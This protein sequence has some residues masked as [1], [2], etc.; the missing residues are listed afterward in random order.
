[1]EYIESELSYSSE[2]FLIFNFLV[3]DNIVSQETQS[4]EMSRA[5]YRI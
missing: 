2:I 3:I 4:T 5:M 1:M